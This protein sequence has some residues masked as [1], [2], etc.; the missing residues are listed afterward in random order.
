MQL[1]S[2]F[3]L[4]FRTFYSLKENHIGLLIA[5]NT[6]IIVLF[7][8]LLMDALKKQPLVKVIALGALLLCGGFA[9]MPLG[10]TFLFGAFTVVVWTTGEMLSLPALTTLIANHSDDSVRG[11]YMG[12]FSFAFALALMVGPAMGST[13]Y[14][15]LGPRTLWFGCGVMGILL[16]LG[17]TFLK[18]DRDSQD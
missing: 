14:D 1:F 3:P 18:K 15:S 12:M 7:E 4:F 10:S 13:I 9:L 5:I 2:T 11:K 17:F 6:V 8:M 16:W